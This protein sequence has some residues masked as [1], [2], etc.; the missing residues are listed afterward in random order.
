MRDDIN[1]RIDQIYLRQQEVVIGKRNVNCLS[2]NGGVTEPVNQNVKG[3]DGKVYRGTSLDKT[4][5]N[6]PTRGENE[7]SGKKQFL[8]LKWDHIGVSSSGKKAN[9]TYHARRMVASSTEGTILMQQLNEF[10]HNNSTPDM[11]N[12]Q[13]HNSAECLD[14]IPE[15][16]IY[17]P[18]T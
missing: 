17:A 9:R 13:T 7:E 4:A 5:N 6:S 3:Q 10:V 8:N 15:K 1:N 14:Q 2:C 12:T 16:V 11:G 18:I